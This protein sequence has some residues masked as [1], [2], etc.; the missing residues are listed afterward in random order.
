MW[1]AN[2]LC[3]INHNTYF[4]K[5]GYTL[6]MNEK[7]A[8]YMTVLS[9]EKYI[10]GVI[11]LKRA[12]KRLK[13][14]HNLVVLIPEERKEELSA[15]LKKN[16]TIEKNGCSICVQPMIDVEI[17]QSYDAGT[18]HW[19]DTFFKLQAAKC[20]EYSKIVL[21]DSDMLVLKNMDFLFEYPNYSATVAGQALHPE[22][23]KLNS[24]LLVIEPS[25]QLHAKLMG[26]IEPAIKRCH[27]N[28]RNVGD[29][30]VFQ[31]AFPS[32]ENHKEL[33]LPEKYNVFYC[34]IDE[35]IRQRIYDYSDIAIVH[36][37]G[38]VKPWSN[39]VF[40]ARNFRILIH[41]LRERKFWKFKVYFRYLKYSFCARK[42]KNEKTV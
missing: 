29:Q 42:G 16:N 14:K 18:S 9:N 28:G 25:E 2:T 41:L 39:G 34:D 33:I 32:W 10:P 40:N 19:R 38:N 23:T 36:F 15:L 12:L 20:T 11:A 8:V 30:D 7:S 1:A 31:E 13:C 6:N 17:K 22:W 27:E 24:G 4:R 3:P 5:Y 37:I 35:I 21:L 26:K